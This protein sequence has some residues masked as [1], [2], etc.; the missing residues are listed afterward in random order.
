MP[1]NTYLPKDDSGKA[2]LLDHVAATLPK[3]TGTLEI[4]ADDLTSLQADAVSFRYA[5][6]ILSRAQS[7]AHNC[8]AFKNLLRDGGTDAI[9]WPV[10]PLLPEPIPP[11]VKSGIIPRFSLLINRLKAHK[12][13]SPAIGQDLQIIGSAYIIDPS[14]WKPVLSSLLQAGHPTVVWAKGKAS[15]IEIWVDRN[16]GTGFVFLIIHTE[17][18]TPDPVPLPSPGTS[19]VWKYKAIYRY[20]DEQVGEWSDVLS[21]VVGG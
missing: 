8:T 16:D 11:I 9:E 3:Y 6:N 19:V 13:Y 2:D 12:N 4:S 15:A 14:T 18:N 5:L 20:H 21:V 7:Y 1:T 17:P 10:A